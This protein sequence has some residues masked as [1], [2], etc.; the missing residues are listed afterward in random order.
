MKSRRRAGIGIVA[1]VATGLALL[2]PPAQAVRATPEPAKRAVIPP[3]ETTLAPQVQRGELAA[4][5]P[6]ALQAAMP[7]VAVA[8][9]RLMDTRDGTGAAKARLTPNT[10]YRLAVVGHG[11]GNAEVA[12]AVALNVTATGSSDAG[13]VTVW[14]CDAAL[15]NTSNLNFAAKQTIPNA[16]VAR[17]SADGFVC[18]QAS[19]AV[20]LI[21]DNDGWFPV[22][23]FVQPK[24]P[25]RL[26]DTRSGAPISPNVAL[27]VQVTGRFDVPTDAS[28][29]LLNVTV[30]GPVSGGFVTVYPCG[31]PVPETSNVNFEAGQTIPNLVLA[32]AGVGGKTCVVSSVATHIIVD[33]MAIFPAVTDVKAQLPARILDT[34]KARPNGTP[35][36]TIHAGEILTVPLKETTAGAPLV[37]E[38]AFLN[39]TAAAPQK[40]GFM[41]VWRC[42][43]AK[44]STSNVNFS[45]GINTAN[46][47]ITASDTGGNVCV[48][49]DT[50]VYL[51]IDVNGLFPPQVNHLVPWATPSG[52]ALPQPTGAAPTT[53]PPATQAVAWPGGLGT[54]TRGPWGY[55]TAVQ[56]PKF[57]G[58]LIITA[59]DGQMYRCSGTVVDR[60]LILTAGHCVL[61]DPAAPFD[62]NNP[63]NP[64][65]LPQ[66]ATHVK[67]HA[68]LYGSSE[69]GTWETATAADIHPS[70]GYYYDLRGDT[71]EAKDLDDTANDFALVKLAPNNQGHIGD[72]TGFIPVRP[73]LGRAPLDK[74]TLHYPAAGFFNAHCTGSSCMPMYCLSPNPPVFQTESFATTGRYVVGNG[75]PL[76]NGSSGAGIFSLFDGQW[77]VVSVVSRGGDRT[78][79]GEPTKAGSTDGAYTVNTIGAE[80]NNDAYPA[81]FQAARAG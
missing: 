2:A 16:V 5:Q 80:L 3:D 22:G 41:T 66:R 7:F 42:S 73:N 75:C 57:V 18:F 70:D 37:S 49:S 79:E 61:D 1:L 63:S 46:L 64:A 51:I 81:L 62:A 12:S 9:R 13:F 6:G 26:I 53:P 65:G 23:S 45:A 15:P 14:P 50:E 20:N 43:D 30:T 78:I 17:I 59:F 34:R 4:T 32:A 60:D 67:F 72:V 25:D 55:L 29:S 21:V 77:W 19:A 11:T 40:A 47:V 68:G 71:P 39:V 36:G 8:P 52:I 38:G 54:V 44:P 28:S 24:R 27:E 58:E 69:I 74:V 76:M 31:Q 48:F 56:T 35:A 33:I 10:A